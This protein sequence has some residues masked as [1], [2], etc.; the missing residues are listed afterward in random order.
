MKAEVAYQVAKELF[1]EELERLLSMLQIDVA[2]LYSPSLVIMEILPKMVKD[3]Q[4]LSKIVKAYFGL[5]NN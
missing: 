5:F 4:R 1:N 3:Y 2:K